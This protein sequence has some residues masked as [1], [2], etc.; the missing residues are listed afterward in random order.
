MFA[1]LKKDGE[2]A[3]K[4]S[5]LEYQYQKLGCCHYTMGQVVCGKPAGL[6]DPRLKPR[7]SGFRMGW[8]AFYNEAR[9]GGRRSA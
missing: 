5:N 6:G 3:H 1:R 2:L 9:R 7:L 8:P 4:D